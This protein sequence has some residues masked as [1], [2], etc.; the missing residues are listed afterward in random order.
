[1]FWNLVNPGYGPIALNEGGGVPTW[2]P[3]NRKWGFLGDSITN[4]STATNAVYAFPRQSIEH[5]GPLH[6]PVRQCVFSGVA[7]NTSAQ[8]LARAA[9]DVPPGNVTGIVILAGSNDAADANAVSAATYAANLTAIIAIYAGKDIIVVTPPPRG[10]ADTPSADEKQRLID[11]RTWILAN[12]SLGYRVADAYAAMVDGSDELLAIYDSG[13]GL[14]PN[15]RGH[16]KIAELVG[17]EMLA[18]QRERTSIVEALNSHNLIA[19]GIMSG[20]LGA[21][22]PTGWFAGAP[23]PTGTA[24][25]LSKVAAPAEAFGQAYR[26]AIAAAANSQTRRA[27][28][29]TSGDGWAIGDRLLFVGKGLVTDTSGDFEE[30]N[31]AT[32]AKAAIQLTNGV[33]GVDFATD[34]GTSYPYACSKLSREMAL[35]YTVASGV[36]VIQPQLHLAL[37]NGSSYAADFYEVGLFNL[38][39]LGYADSIL[40]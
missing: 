4:G 1:M 36:T 2:F 10:S 26:I 11:Y 24:A 27:T 7:G 15:N 18:T 17:V 34:Q 30:Q 9:T 20:S 31:A 14:H 12:T 5:A 38:T 37:P 3:L 19:N 21:G 39:R 6:N 13:D 22:S 23:T 16:F 29:A 25:T 32:A 8:I 28:A 35:S 33:S 40:V